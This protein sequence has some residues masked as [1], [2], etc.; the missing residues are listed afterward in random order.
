MALR[1]S[2]LPSLLPLLV[3]CLLVP[4]AAS[5][6]RISFDQFSSSSTF[7]ALGATSLFGFTWGSGWATNNITNPVTPILTLPV[8][9]ETSAYNASGDS[10]L[11]DFPSPLDF[12]GGFFRPLDLNME[13]ASTLQ[14]LG[15]DSN[16]QLVGQSPVTTLAGTW[17]FIPAGFAGVSRIELRPGGPGKFFEVDD[18][19]VAAEPTAG[20]GLAAAAWVALRRRARRGPTA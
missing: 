5:A 14:L 2:V 16:G 1:R 13:P 17:Q 8:S 11:I 12:V 18:L 9:G 15:F 7:S 20:L 4:S 3:A 10:I 6:L 19:R